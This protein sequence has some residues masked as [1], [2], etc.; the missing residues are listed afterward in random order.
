MAKRF[1]IALAALL[2]TSLSSM[3]DVVRYGYAP[4]QFAEEEMIAQGSGTNGF[5]AGMICLDPS[6]DPVVKRLEGHTVKGVRCYF[7]N[8][9]KQSRQSRS[10]VLYATGTPDNTTSKVCDFVKGWNEIY[11]DEPIVIG[12][13][14]IYVGLQVYEL[15]GTPYP[16]VTYGPAD[17]QGGCWV[18]LE[19]EGWAEYTQRGTLMIQAIL[20]EEAAPKLEK[21]V[22]ASVEKSPL[23]VAPA[24]TF[25]G[26]VFIHNMSDEEVSSI[27]LQTL[28][29]GDTEPYV[30]EITFAEPL[31][32][33]EGR[34]FDRPVRAGV[35]TGMTQ[36]LKLSVSAMNGQPTQPTMDGLS[37]H[38]VTVDA[39]NRI[40]LIEEFTSQ[41]CTNCPFMIY[42]LDMAM[43]MYG[44]PLV[45]VTHH[46]GFQ[47]DM[48]TKPVD[49]ELTYLFG[50]KALMN[51]A[52][53]YDRWVPEGESSPIFGAQ[54][55][56][57]DPYLEQIQAAAVRPAMA[58]VEF[59]LR[60]D[61]NAKTVGCT[62]SGR[63][64][65]SIVS[66]NVPTYLSVY[67]I[68]DHIPVTEEYFQLGLE[69]GDGAPD[70]LQESFR[71]NGIKRHDFTL[72]LGGDLLTTDENGNYSVDYADI[73]IDP[74][75]N[76]ENLKVIGYVCKMDKNNIRENGVLNA[77]YEH[78][79]TANVI[80]IDSDLAQVDFKVTRDRRIVATSDVANFSIFNL[81]GVAVDK[82]DA[83]V[84]GIYIVSF[85]AADGQVGA[86][87]LLVK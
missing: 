62:V 49:E 84:P 38:H 46:S 21:M 4:E 39:F 59:D 34:M 69:E 23:V 54:L 45:Y 35:E 65:T 68:E 5:C 79:T 73:A 81:Q 3:A 1:F 51:P 28:G 11:F 20:D 2:V 26:K 74:S 12:A 25:D 27:T 66:A 14:P 41:V 87:K 70:D 67:L 9:Y 8:D 16:L 42:Y 82:N 53:M 64:S 19:N 24:D 60:Y 44:G 47:K 80:S 57:P 85:K 78:L 29:Q 71:H 72:T 52:V 48:F 10:K 61:E 40:P 31:A 33:H 7:V 86:K 32:A 17:I 56:E 13:E 50:S 63:V 77:N 22:Y 58:S 55:A 76:V 6:L 37:V 30:E 36:W 83:L 75:W 43:E 18:N 15:R